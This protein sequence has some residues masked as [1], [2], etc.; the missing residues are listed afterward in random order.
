[1][2]LDL[3]KIKLLSSFNLPHANVG[4]NA[5]SCQLMKNSDVLLA[6]RILGPS[7]YKIVNNIIHEVV[8]ARI[9]SD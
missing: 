4:N 3:L 9:S 7:H 2:S 1:M 6:L 8:S 5:F